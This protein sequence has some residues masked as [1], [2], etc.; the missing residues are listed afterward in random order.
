MTGA[1]TIGMIKEQAAGMATA[2]V[3]RRHGLGP[4]TFCKLKAKFR[5][6]EDESARLKRLMADTMLD[7]IFWE[8]TYDA[9]QAA[10]GCAGSDVGSRH[11][12]TPSLS[13][14]TGVRK[15]MQ[16]V[17][18]RRVGPAIAGSASCPPG[19]QVTRAAVF[20]WTGFWSARRQTS[21]SFVSLGTK[22]RNTPPKD[23]LCGADKP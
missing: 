14:C 8:I 19:G 2:E 12:A 22:G 7:N 10:R 1:Q 18:G 21:C 20:W 23:Q 6:L 13:A 9:D 17:A 11:F 4:S 15:E 3:C 16:G 5:D